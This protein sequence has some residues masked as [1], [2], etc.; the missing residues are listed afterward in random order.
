MV[1]IR[2]DVDDFKRLS[3]FEW[4][5]LVPLSVATYWNGESGGGGGMRSLYQHRIQAALVPKG[6]DATIR[7]PPNLPGF[8]ISVTEDRE[9]R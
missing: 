6:T 7:D 8:G 1:A 4:D 5:A 3:S 2:I 9:F